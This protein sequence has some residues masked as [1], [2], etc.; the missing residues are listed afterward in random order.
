MKD[1]ILYYHPEF[2]KILLAIYLIILVL[3]MVRGAL[4]ETWFVESVGYTVGVFIVCGLIAMQLS[5]LGRKSSDFLAQINF[6]LGWGSF[7]LFYSLML[8]IVLIIR[9]LTAKTEY[10]QINK[11]T[12]KVELIGSWLLGGIT[13]AIVGGSI[14][15]FVLGLGPFT[16]FL[17]NI[18]TNITVR[19]VTAL[20]ILLTVLGS[21]Y[22]VIIF[23]TKWIEKVLNIGPIKRR[24]VKVQT[25]G[26]NDQIVLKNSSELK[27]D[28]N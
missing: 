12:G 4:E 22:V 16:K 21:P 8:I 13:G 11:K 3:A 2:L 20:P 23:Y 14:T 25:T 15:F 7:L 10:I 26:V 9:C 18:I 24:I 6:G 28:D 19:R 1:V 17:G 5:S 27:E